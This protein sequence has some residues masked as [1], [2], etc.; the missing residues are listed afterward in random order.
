MRTLAVVVLLTLASIPVFATYSGLIA[1]P[2]TDVLATGKL[3]LDVDSYYTPLSG[4]EG[5]AFINSG[6]L[7][8]PF[9]RMEA[10]I[11]V[12]SGSDKPVLFNAKYQVVSPNETPAA[13]ALGLFNLGFDA[14]PVYYGVAS[15]AFTGV[16]LTGGYYT[17]DEEVLGDDDSGVMLGLDGCSGKF[18][19]AA[20]Y[21]GGDNALGSWNV[22][23]GY[24]LAD[25]VGIIV[26][27]DNYNLDELGEAINIQIDVNLN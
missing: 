2:S 5:G 26:G 18:W 8:G 15:Y 16:R 9:P 4:S 12:I 27:Y 23:V 6:L 21:F 10:G 1:I 17:G 7:Y 3:H 25:N 13:L 20:D 11:D 19:L 22:G 24:P 14:D